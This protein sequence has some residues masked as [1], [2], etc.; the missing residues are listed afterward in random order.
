MYE[1]IVETAP[2]NASDTTQL[3]AQERKVQDDG[4][5]YYT[6]TVH[7]RPASD[8]PKPDENG[9]IPTNEQKDQG[10]KSCVITLE[11]G[12]VYVKNILT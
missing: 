1:R 7:S 12:C 5:P 2:G 8:S 11:I 6:V 3:L 10:K 9:V 4:T